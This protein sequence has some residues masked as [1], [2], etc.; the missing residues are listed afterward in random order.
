M[1]KGTVVYQFSS[2][3]EQALNGGSYLKYSFGIFVVAYKKHTD[4][5]FEY[6]HLLDITLLEGMSGLINAVA[7]RIDYMDLH[8]P[9][10]VVGLSVLKDYFKIQADGLKHGYRRSAAIKSMLKAFH[11]RGMVRVAWDR[12]TEQFVEF[13]EVRLSR[14]LA[15]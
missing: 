13:N 1:R 12:V 10:Y 7:P 3:P 11:K 2:R 14:R 6:E 4:S 8:N 15:L 5:K 9:K